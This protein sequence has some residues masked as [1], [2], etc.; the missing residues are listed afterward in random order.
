VPFKP[1]LFRLFLGCLFGLGQALVLLGPELG[2]LPVRFSVFGLFARLKR[3]HLVGP[4][5]GQAPAFSPYRRFGI[6]PC[7]AN[8]FGHH[9]Q[10][11]R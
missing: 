3:Q 7:Q 1:I 5:Q 4:L 10:L 8:G 6:A 2:Q 9:I 11:R